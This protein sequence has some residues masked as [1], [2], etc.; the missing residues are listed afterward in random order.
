MK[1]TV[2]L[3]RICS[4]EYLMRS[5]KSDQARPTCDKVDQV[6]VKEVHLI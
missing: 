1:I 5:Y 6:H 4:I 3:D 2:A